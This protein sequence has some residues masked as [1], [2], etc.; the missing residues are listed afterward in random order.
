MNLSFFPLII[1]D[2]SSGLKGL[3]K[4][5]ITKA[6]ESR[7]TDI[8]FFFHSERHTFWNAF[9]LPHPASQ[10]RH[11]SPGCRERGIAKMI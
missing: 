4:K 3:K 2:A 5:I 9:V 7:T 8:S 6:M 1:F 11:P 10:A